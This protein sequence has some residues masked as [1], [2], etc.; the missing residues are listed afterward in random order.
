VLEL[1]GAGVDG[2]GLPYQRL[3]EAACNKLPYQRLCEVS[4]GVR[5][6]WCS[7]VVVFVGDGVRGWLMVDSWWSFVECHAGCQNHEFA[8]CTLVVTSRRT[9]RTT[10]SPPTT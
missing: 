1:A 3:S 8:N 4:G 9:H 2:N 6:Q 5:G 10:A 7:W